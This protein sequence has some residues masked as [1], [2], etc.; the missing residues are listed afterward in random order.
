MTLTAIKRVDETGPTIDSIVIGLSGRFKTSREAMGLVLQF[1]Y[2][3]VLA[4]VNGR[5]QREGLLP[6]RRRQPNTA[7]TA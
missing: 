3:A 2:K 6:D 5:F 7:S 1:D 4:M